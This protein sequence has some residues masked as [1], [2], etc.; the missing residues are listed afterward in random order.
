MSQKH[1][2]TADRLVTI[3]LSVL[4]LPGRIFEEGLHTLAALPWADVVQ[5][6]L[7][8]SAG[9]AHTRVDYREGTPRWAI[10][11]AYIIPEVVG[12]TA[13]IAVIGYWLVGGDIWLPA[14]NLD[15]VLLSLL[16]AQWLAVALPSAQDANQTAE[17]EA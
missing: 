1:I 7:D 15:W 11:V 8:P 10:K 4:F 12:W 6:E 5:I 2:R 3:F 9:T 17:A 16:G 13:G 14:T